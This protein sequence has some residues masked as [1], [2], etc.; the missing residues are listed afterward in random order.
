MTTPLVF[1][2]AGRGHSNQSDVTRT[3]AID[4]I[5]GRYPEGAGLPRDAE[6]SAMFNVSRTVLRESMKTLSAKGLIAAKA[7][8]GTRVR[9]R[10]AWN[11]FDPDLLA[12]HLEAGIDKR[13]MRDL[14]DIRLAVEPRTAAL[15]AERRTEEMVV[16][17]RDWLARMHAAP[18][19]SADFADADLA[20]HLEIATASG[21][22]FM[23]SIGAVIEAALRASFRLSA[24]V[25]DGDRK[26]TL[27]AH[28]AIVDAIAAGDGQGAADAMTE[29]IFNGL[30]RH[31]STPS[32]PHPYR[33]AF[34]AGS[35]AAAAPATLF[36]APPIERPQS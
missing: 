1:I 8:V 4:I 15:A 20:L 6:L 12:W 31:G 16:A 32:R 11:M 35:S 18:S 21:N 33:P 9:E 29:V 22:P 2:P 10:A 14:A 34:P 24:P 27:A 28:G 36:P 17:I 26:A 19:D 13:F 5:S 23:R 30:R 25:E 7:K 3:L